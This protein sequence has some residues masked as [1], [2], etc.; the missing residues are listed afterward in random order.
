VSGLSIMLAGDQGHSMGYDDSSTS[1]Q[2]HGM[3]HED[4]SMGQQ[5]QLCCTPT[6][7]MGGYV[8]YN[9]NDG[10]NMVVVRTSSAVHHRVQFVRMFT[11]PHDLSVLILES[12]ISLSLP[13]DVRI[14]LSGTLIVVY[15]CFFC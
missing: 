5:E 1:Q 10:Q 11:I 2:G 3:G 9:V 7:V 8:Q 6:P 14:S 13:N 4:P 15:K 12:Y